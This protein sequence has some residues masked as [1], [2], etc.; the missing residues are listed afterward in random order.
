MTPDISAAAHH[1]HLLDEEAESFTYQTFDDSPKKDPKLARIIHGSIEDPKVFLE[2]IRLSQ[3]GAGVFVTVNATDGHGRK[4]ENITRVRA[5]WVEQDTAGGAQLPVDPHIVIESSPGKYHKYV[6]VDDAPL[7][8]FKGVQMRMVTSYASDPNARDISR[9]LR[10]AGFPHQKSDP[11]MVRIIEEHR[12]PPLKWGK[13]KTIFPPAALTNV[14]NVQPNK[15]GKVDANRN[16]YLTSYAGTLRKR[17][18]EEHTILSMLLALNQEECSPPLPAA[19]VQTIARSVGSYETSNVVDMADYV[20][21]QEAP[22]GFTLPEEISKDEW[23]TARTAPPCIVEDLLYQDVS[24]IVAGGGTGK[25]T[26]LLYES[27]CLILAL[28]LYGRK[29]LRPGA[30]LFIS[31]EDPRG[32][33]VARAREICSQMRLT[34]DQMQQVREEL[35]IKDQS[36]SIFRLTEIKKDV[37]ELHPNVNEVVKAIKAHNTSCTPITMTI[38]D[39]MV[40]FSTGEERGN[41]AAQG[42]IMACRRIT[43]MTGSGTQMCHHISQDS[44]RGQQKDQYAARGGTALSDGA[45][46]IRNLHKCEPDDKKIPQILDGDQILIMNI[47]KTTYCKPQKDVYLSRS[48]YIFDY[49]DPDPE[50]SDTEQS[51]GKQDQVMQF[52]KSRLGYPYSSN[53]R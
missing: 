50:R 10:L 31:A 52:V 27:I 23:N 46:T 40:S 15:D 25:T 17:G 26:L 2:L 11:W 19:E 22:P 34:E 1:L 13:A 38:F 28:P 51:R 35:L 41:D 29:I 6:L 33:L 16:T 5:I 37:I 8:E 18:L 48:G 53:S 14:D 30:V 24:L 49:A 3:A 44:F 36:S 42:M 32:T 12:I 7:S 47:P 43:A 39:P 45:R 21:K 9:V 20:A 4:T